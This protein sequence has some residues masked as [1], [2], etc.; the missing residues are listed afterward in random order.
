MKVLFYSYTGFLIIIFGPFLL[1][2][3]VFGQFVGAFYFGY[4]AGRRWILDTSKALG[5]YAQ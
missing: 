5:E 3:A 1:V 2:G 4:K